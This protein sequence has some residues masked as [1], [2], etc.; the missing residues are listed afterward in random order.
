MSK[1]LIIG[2]TSAIA[3]A[4]ARLL[5][6]ENAE[7]FLVARNAEKLDVIATDLKNIIS[8]TDLDQVAQWPQ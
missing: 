4:T 7:L 5:A 8:I 3:T 6:T 1:I 2:A